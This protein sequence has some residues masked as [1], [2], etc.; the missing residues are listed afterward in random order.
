MAIVQDTTERESG[1]QGW[2]G[3]PAFG[4]LALIPFPT[5]GRPLH[6]T[7]ASSAGGRLTR[8]ETAACELEGREDRG[9][10]QCIPRM[11]F[12]SRTRSRSASDS[13][14]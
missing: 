1:F 12:R 4:L 5:V 13:R 7:H 10:S 8:R 3:G 14:E 6:P 2:S 11:C 9:T